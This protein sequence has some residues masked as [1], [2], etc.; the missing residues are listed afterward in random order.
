[1]YRLLLD[2]DGAPAPVDGDHSVAPGVVHLIGENRGAL[3]AQA[4][5]SQRVGQAVAMEDVVAQRE[6]AWVH[7]DEFPTD[8]KRLGDPVGSRLHGVTQRQTPLASVAQKLQE[9]GCGPRSR[10]HQDV[11]NP[12]KHQNA[13]RI[14][15]HRLVV[16]RQQLLAHRGRDGVKPRALTP[17]EDYSLHSPCLPH[18]TNDSRFTPDEP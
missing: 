15:D 11:P 2:G 12:G 7:P 8:V 17:R 13:Q 3:A 1:M 4:G 14:V 6:R 16:D 9:R 10:D 18:S 5:R